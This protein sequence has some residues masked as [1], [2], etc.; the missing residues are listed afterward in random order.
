M[1][2]YDIFVLNVNSVKVKN[3]IRAISIAKVK[4]KV[5]SANIMVVFMRLRYFVHY[6]SARI[7]QDSKKLLFILLPFDLQ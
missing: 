6:V 1:R 4:I 7:R 3:F 5:K 2:L